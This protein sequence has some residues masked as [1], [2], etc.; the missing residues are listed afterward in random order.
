M[1]LIPV[2]LVLIWIALFFGSCNH[3]PSHES[4]SVYNG[5]K[6]VAF[7][8]S[9][10]KFDS[11]TN[12]YKISNKNLAKKY[13]KK[14]LSLA[15]Q[16]NTEEALSHAFLIMGVAF[17]YQNSDSSYFYYSRALKIAQKHN[18]DWVKSKAFYN[19]AMMYLYASDQK[20]AL[21]FLDSS[22]TSSQNIKDFSMLSNAYNTLGNLKLDLGD[23]ADSKVMYD[24]ALRISKRNNISKQMGIAM[25]SL[26]RFEKQ[27]VSSEKMRKTAIEILKRQPGNEEEIATIL[28]NIGARDPNPDTARKYY[29]EAIRIAQ[30]GNCSEVEINAYNNLAYSFIDLGKPEKAE[31]FLIK[32]AIP[33]AEGLEN[34]D[35]LS[36]LYDT[37]CDISIAS[38]NKGQALENER[39]SLQMRIKAD[40]RQASDQ[41][42]LLAALLNV[43]N[44]ELRI[45]NNEKEIQKRDNKITMIIF[46]LSVSL[47]L[48]VMTIILYNWKI[49]RNKLK[50]QDSLLNS[51][52]KLIDIEEN[53][54]GRVAMELH[55]LT[56]PFYT[57]MM[58]Q[59]EKARIGDLQVETELKNHLSVMTES[60]REISHRMDNNFIGQLTIG[61]LIKGLCKDLQHASVVNIYCNIYPL[62]EELTDE[63]TIHLYRMVQ[64]IM[65][66]AVK[67]VKSGEIRLSISEESGMFVILYKDSGP[68]FDE[69]KIRNKGLGIS[70]IFERARMINAKAILRTSPGQGTQWNIVLPVNPKKKIEI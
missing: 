27:N 21:I 12:A 11:L 38:G 47:M 15:F 19:L 43:K 42:R 57:V 65:T 61:E 31:E 30:K 16:S 52:K 50:Y 68:G 6:N 13:A 55:D 24:S 35:L 9:M 62:K 4:L 33:L 22:I 58:Q 17:S 34:Y 28:N 26:S 66:N 56:T 36:N 1:K 49:Q 63:E 69:N 7:S 20:T 32:Y 60:I 25:A 54:K 39:K 8:D 59:I 46:F 40:A 44:K 41:V 64:E 23:S 18:I 53:L 5:A 67:Y 14:A 2:S 10:N 37:Y 29:E 51:A 45:Q 70:N 3:N 48:L